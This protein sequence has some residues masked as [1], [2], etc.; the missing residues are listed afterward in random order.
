M[1][2]AASISSFHARPLTGET[3]LPFPPLV[4]TVLLPIL[5]FLH[6]L[7]FYCAYLEVWSIWSSSLFTKPSLEACIEIL[8][9]RDRLRRDINLLAISVRASEKPT[10]HY[11]EETNSGNYE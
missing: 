9:T 4:R 10:K 2:P 5:H 11:V 7:A 6:I 3:S 1:S 8:G